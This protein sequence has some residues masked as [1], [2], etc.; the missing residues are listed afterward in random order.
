MATG[1][2]APQKRTLTGPTVPCLST[3]SN[4][5]LITQ[6]DGLWA[7]FYGLTGADVIAVEVCGSEQ[8]LNDKRARYTADPSLILTVDQRWL[9]TTTTL[10]NGSQKRWYEATGT[11]D[12]KD[13]HSSQK[14]KHHIPVRFLR[15]LFVLPEST[16]T[17][18][19]NR[20][21]PKD[22]EF[23]IKQSSLKSYKSQKAQNFLKEMSTQPDHFYTGK[24]P[25]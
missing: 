12:D 15:V 4:N 24:K 3:S 20:Y 2:D 23:F 13:V 10:Q 16:Y 7:Y 9:C 1:S 25:Q 8:N 17:K 14:K 18:W 19:L 22:H 21:T 5:S 11:I 6:P